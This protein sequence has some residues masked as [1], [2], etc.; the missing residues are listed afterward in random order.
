MMCSGC[1]ALSGSGT[2]SLPGIAIWVVQTACNDIYV[3][4]PVSCWVEFCC[5][6]ISQ[7]DLN[8]LPH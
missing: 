5:F 1:G 6:V 3:S 8:R 4:F 2:L 7:L